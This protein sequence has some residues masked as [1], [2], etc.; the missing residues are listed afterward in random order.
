VNVN[1]S[2][3][4]PTSGAVKDGVALFASLNFTDGPAVCVHEYANVSPS[5]SLLEEPSS[6]TLASSLTV[7]SGPA[8]AV[9]H[10]FYVPFTVL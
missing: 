7:W 4:D 10:W 5:G 1:L 2:P 3:A 8:F 9:G 6:C